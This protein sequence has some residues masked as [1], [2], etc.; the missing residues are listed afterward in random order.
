MLSLGLG[1]LTVVSIWQAWSLFNFANNF[2][3]PMTIR[4]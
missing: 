2:D 1:S 3:I 4:F